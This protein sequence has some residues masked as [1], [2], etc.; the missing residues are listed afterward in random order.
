MKIF[1][2]SFMHSFQIKPQHLVFPTIFSPFL[3]LVSCIDGGIISKH[4]S[5]ESICIFYLVLFTLPSLFFNHYVEVI[6]TTV[7]TVFVSS[8]LI[9]IFYQRNHFFYSVDE[10]GITF[11]ILLFSMFLFI[12][13][14]LVFFLKKYYIRTNP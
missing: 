7:L 13:H 12:S 3:F 5:T 9:Y 8:I 2:E 4:F 1:K 6:Y 11:H 14:S 10:R